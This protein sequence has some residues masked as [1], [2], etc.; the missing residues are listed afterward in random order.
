MNPLLW[1]RQ[2]LRIRRCE[3]E[4]QRAIVTEAQ[5]SKQNIRQNFEKA[6]QL[7]AEATPEQLDAATVCLQEMSNT[8]RAQESRPLKS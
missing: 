1:L 6:K 8:L 5:E 2:L 3:K 4:T 7:I